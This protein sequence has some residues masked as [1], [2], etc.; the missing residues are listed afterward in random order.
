MSVLTAARR[1]KSS[2]LYINESL[3]PTREAISYALRKAKRAMPDKISGSNSFD[4]RVYVWVKPPDAAARS[5]RTPINTIEKLKKF[6][7][8][9][10]GRPMQDFLPNSPV[11]T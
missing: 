11:L 7:E 6:C 8:Q 10:L 5:V 1:V 4:G 2:N 9:T 3:T